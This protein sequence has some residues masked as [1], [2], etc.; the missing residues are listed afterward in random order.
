[1][2]LYEYKC[3]KCGHQFEV[4][5]GVTGTVEHCERCNGPVRKVFSAVGIIFKGSGFHINDYRKTPAPVEGDAKKSETPA[6]AS[7]STSSS[8]GSSDGAAGGGSDAKT[9][10]AP[11]AGAKSS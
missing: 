4:T 6:P 5:H 11:S 1:M 10:A 9:P 3:T 8:S 7:T 2:P